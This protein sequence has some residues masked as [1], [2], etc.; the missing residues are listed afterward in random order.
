MRVRINKSELRGRVAVPPSKS[1][2]IRSLMCAALAKGK[3]RI[4]NPL[5]C[6]DTE[7]ASEALGKVGIKIEKNEGCWEVTGGRFHAPEGDIYC[8]DSAATLRFMTSLSSIIPGN[9]AWFR[10][11]RLPN[12]LSSH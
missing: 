10:A 3:S 12:A 6:D 11:R 8:R 9:A 4:I 7:A 5:I 2:T 1:Y